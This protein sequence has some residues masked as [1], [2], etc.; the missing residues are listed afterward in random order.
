MQ[1]A[2]R[3]IVTPNFLLTA[4]EGG[5]YDSLISHYRIRSAKVVFDE[6]TP[7]PLDHNDSKAATP[8]GSFALLLHGIQPAGTKASKAWY[9]L[10]KVGK[11]GYSRK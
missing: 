4:S 10:R 2:P 5:K 7:L 3:G 6:N 1:D 8:G 11:A 9:A